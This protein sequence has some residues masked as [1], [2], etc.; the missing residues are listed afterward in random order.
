MTMH[1][2][3][4]RYDE[5][6]GDRR[7][8]APVTTLRAASL[9]LALVLVPA[10]AADG[11]RQP[12]EGR[13]RAAGPQLVYERIAGYWQAADH[14]ALAELV[15]VDGLTVAVAPETE[16]ENR[17]RPSQAFYFFRNLFQSVETVDFRFARWRA[18]EDQDGLHAVAE[19]VYRRSGSE[20]IYKERLFFALRSVEG[21]LML[22]EIRTLR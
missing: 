11:A 6:S 10:A 14:V 22:T 16:R 9:A 5:R 7:R 4:E 3:S 8:P 21:R 2:R 20:K 18:G 17:Y 1:D 15:D 13:S 19:W 12:E